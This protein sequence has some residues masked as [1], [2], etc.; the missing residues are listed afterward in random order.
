MGALAADCKRAAGAAADA[1]LIF[2]LSFFAV[3]FAVGCIMGLIELWRL[4]CT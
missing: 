4:I 2:F 1:L 3:E